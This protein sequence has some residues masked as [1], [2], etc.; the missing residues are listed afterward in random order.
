M[1]QATDIRSITLSGVAISFQ[2]FPLP[3]EG[4][5]AHRPTSH[6]RLPLG[7]VR[8][9]WLLPMAAGEAFWIGLG[10][11]AS[12]DAPIGIAVAVR[13]RGRRGEHNVP[14]ILVPPH[15]WLHG[16]MLRDGRIAAFH[17][18]ATTGTPACRRLRFLAG[19]AEA[20]VWPVG[21][22]RFVRATGRAPPDPLDPTA[23]YRG[24]RLP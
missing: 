12:A 6:G 17:R 10:P 24:W 1:S 2:R 22:A 15:R 16:R 19:G 18:S 8:G 13:V 7:S 21:Y 4:I 5:V 3:P 14:A 20:I 11:A 9:G 23:A